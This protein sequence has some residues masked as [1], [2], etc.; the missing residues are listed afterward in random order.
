MQT[1][2]DEEEKLEN[3]TNTK[4]SSGFNA[5]KRATRKTANF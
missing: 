5:E 1:T 4:F 3:P 2:A